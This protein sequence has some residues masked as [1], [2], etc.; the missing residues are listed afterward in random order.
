MA[1]SDVKIRAL[2]LPEKPTKV[3][4]ERGLYLLLSKSGSKLWRFKY[5]WQGKEKLLTFGSH[6][7]VSL[8]DAR[9]KRDEARSLIANGTD[10]GVEKK[11]AAL[12][13]SL[14]AANTFSSVAEELINKNELEGHADATLAKAR[15]FLSIFEPAIGT[16]PVADVTPH[17]LLDALKKVERQGHRET[18]RRM[19]SAMR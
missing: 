5:R 4:D 1:L 19:R 18:A 17:E 2:K 10:P 8:K 14:N 3:P 7:D 6:P 12:A 9:A 13:A 15:W 11:H 16:R